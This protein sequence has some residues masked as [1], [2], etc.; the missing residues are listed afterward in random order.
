VIPVCALLIFDFLFMF[1][2]GGIAFE[3]SAHFFGR[4]KPV[5]ENS[6]DE[7]RAKN[8]RVELVKH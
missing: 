3:L 6:T 7:G 4:T 2:A 1:R 5:A 8:R